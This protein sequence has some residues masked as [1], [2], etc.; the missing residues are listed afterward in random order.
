M[1]NVCGT[2]FRSLSNE[3]QHFMV[4]FFIYFFVKKFFYTSINFVLSRFMKKL[5][6][7]NKY[8]LRNAV[9]LLAHVVNLPAQTHGSTGLR[10]VEHTKEH[11]SNLNIKSY[12][13]TSGVRCLNI[14]EILSLVLDNIR[15]IALPYNAT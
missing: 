14:S 1:A 8:G 12:C 7:A 11:S 13:Q 4:F 2:S 6:T 15:R 10:A 9:V 5:S 3:V